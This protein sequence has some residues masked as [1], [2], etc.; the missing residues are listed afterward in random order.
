MRPLEVVVA[1][2]HA[3]VRR[4]IRRA[5]EGLGCRVSGEA[6]CAEEAVTLARDHRPDIAL[7][8]IR[9]PGSGIRAA[10]E[11]SSSC[12]GT[13]VVMLTVSEDAED[14]VDAMAAG[15]RGYL[16]KTTAPEDLP[17][18]LHR[19]RAGQPL[20]SP[21]LL[22]PVLDQLRSPQRRLAGRPR[23]SELLSAREWE[24]MSLLATGCTTAEA[25]RRLFLSSTTV[26]VHVASVVR[27]LRVAS[28]AEALDLLRRGG[29]PEGPLPERGE[30]PPPG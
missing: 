13:A 23:G 29:V 17:A 12:P 27:K 4:S 9:M 11:I 3:G 20:L 19:L 7:L 8:D 15:A 18:M 6:G 30:A 10:S 16:L 24:V 1:D 28:R 25:S 14:I 5:V 21:E 22:G 26:R 2:D